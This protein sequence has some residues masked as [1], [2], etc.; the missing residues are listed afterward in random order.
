M[1]GIMMRHKDNYS[2]A[3]RK[4]DQEI[5]VKIEEY[6]SVFG[7]L[8]LM[9]KPILR[10][11]G[12][13][14]DSLVIGTKCIMYSASFFEEEEEEEEAGGL[15][16]EE[17]AKKQKKQEREEKYFMYFTVGLS[18]ILSVG[19]FMIL[20]Y[21]LASLFRKIGATETMITIIEAFV[22][23]FLFLGY[24]LLISRMKDIQRLF[25]YHGAEHKCINCVEQG[26]DLTVENVM[27]SSRQ[28]QRCGTSFLLL[29]MLVSI[30]AHFLFVAVPVMWI[31]VA[32]RIL[33]V[34]V[35][36]G[37]S[38]ECIQWTGKSDHPLA[39]MLSK[40]GLALQKL[41]TREPDES[42]AEVAIAAVEAVFDWKPYVEEVRREQ[43]EEHV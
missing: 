41:S 36:A 20:P 29:V 25:M 23:I 4:P 13:F 8:K 28:H 27:R 38:Y 1:E 11:V 17:I 12:S 43:A 16:E 7:K 33:M 42:M 18:V 37:V 2:V 3:V 5:I 31:R 35:V 34:P 22:K 21:L 32:A 15:T 10:G 9:K 40:P 14:V 30:A 26:L 24:M 6:K 39:R 19:L